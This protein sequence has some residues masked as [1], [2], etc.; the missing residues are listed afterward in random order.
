MRFPISVGDT[1]IDNDPRLMTAPGQHKRGVV[2]GVDEHYVVV[3]WDGGKKQS[4]ISRS[5]IR[6]RATPLRRNGYTLI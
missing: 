1:L 5:R 4:K 6:N 2:I 3:H